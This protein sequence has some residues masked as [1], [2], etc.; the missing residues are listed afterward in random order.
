MCRGGE[1]GDKS[2]ER[3]RRAAERGEEKK[4]G[5]RQAGTRELR[6]SRGEIEPNPTAVRAYY[7]KR[8]KLGALL[9]LLPPRVH[10]T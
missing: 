8:N 7:Q 6:R 1:R 9:W 2:G 3:H 5:G 4:A 10:A